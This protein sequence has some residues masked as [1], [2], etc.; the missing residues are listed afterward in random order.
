M[1]Q[2]CVIVAW[3][4][5]SYRLKVADGSVYWG[6][7]GW[8]KSGEIYYIWVRVTLL[9]GLGGKSCVALGTAIGLIW[10]DGSGDAW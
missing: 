7:S 8:D 4:T 9:D 2:R 1:A 3:T 6:K 10:M 5:R